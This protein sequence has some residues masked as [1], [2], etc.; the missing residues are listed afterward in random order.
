MARSTDRQ[1][2]P[3]LRSRT[4]VRV[5]K[6]AIDVVLCF[7]EANERL[8]LQELADRTGI[9]KATAFRIVSALVDERILDQPTAGGPYELGFF[10]LRCADAILAASE[11]RQRAFPIMA[12]LR[13]ELNETIVL[14]ERHGDSILNVDKVSGRQGIIEAPTIGVRTPLHESSAGLAVLSTLGAEEL[15]AYLKAVDA[16]PSRAQALRKRVGDVKALIADPATAAGQGPVLAVP[17]IGSAGEA[18]GALSIAVP[19]GRLDPPLVERCMRRLIGAAR[20]LRP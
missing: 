17:V 15:G 19:S 1:R 5:I 12:R 13:D 20:Q 4:G 3:P 10:A 6:R 7:D 16:T 11:L 2:K 18:I 9:H 14:A 8:T